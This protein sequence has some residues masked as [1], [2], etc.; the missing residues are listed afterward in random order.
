MSD[1]TGLHQRRIGTDL[2]AAILF[3]DW[4]P[5]GRYVLVSAGLTASHPGVRRVN[6]QTGRAETIRDDSSS[7]RCPSWAPDGK[8]FV[9]ASYARAHSALLV[10]NDRGTVLDTLV[11]S[12][13]TYL[14]CPQ[15]SPTGATILFTVFHG[16]GR[17][18]WERPAFHSNLA[19]LSL[20]S[21]KVTQLTHDSGLTNYGKWSRDGDWIV[22][23]SDRHATPTQSEEGVA[24]MLQHLEIWIMK[25]TGAGLRRLTDNDIF[26]AHPSW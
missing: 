5:D 17:S 13:S 26:D 23:Q 24:A 1:A 21:G 9:V 6:V 20:A 25:A 8:R 16:D 2:P 19:I 18:G 7:Y 15:W 10:M 3:P 11:R 12:D 14:D 4:S 22:F